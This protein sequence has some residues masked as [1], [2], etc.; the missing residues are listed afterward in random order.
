MKS[1]SGNARAESSGKSRGTPF[2]SIKSKLYISFGFLIVVFLI[3][4]AGA[5]GIQWYFDYRVTNLFN[6]QIRFS[7]LVKSSES[8]LLEIQ[9]LER[10]F[11]ATY[12]DGGTDA[13]KALLT[14]TGN[15]FE[16]IHGSLRDIQQLSV[17]QENIDMAK[18]FD[19]AVTSYEK[20]L[21]AVVAL[22]EK[23]IGPGGVESQLR[24]AGQALEDFFRDRTMNVSG[25]Q[26]MRMYEQRYL[27]GET[28]AGDILTDAIGQIKSQMDAARVAETD[29]ELLDRLCSAYAAALEAT[30][31][32]DAQ[33][34]T[35]ISQYRRNDDKIQP[36]LW[37]FYT[38]GLRDKNIA[39]ENMKRVV[40][41][42][43]AATAVCILLFLV[44]GFGR[45]VQLS[46]SITRQV[47]HI[48]NIFEKIGI[49]D[50]SARAEVT[51]NDEL[52]AMAASLNGML[53]NIFELIQT[54]EERNSMQAS[55]MKLLDDVSGIADGDLS[56]EAEVTQDFTGAIA[57]AFNFAIVQL[58]Q[59]VHNVQDST[60]RVSSSASDISSAAERLAA[61][62]E[63][64]AQRISEATSKMGEMAVAA[65]GVA[66]KAGQSAAVSDQALDAAKQGA[67][68]VLDTIGGMNRIRDKV[69]E[70]AKRIKRLGE[71]SQEIG[72]IVQMIN[73]IADRTSI[74]AMNASIQAAM[75]G[76]SGRGFAVVAEE[77]ER[78]AQ[79]S[80]KSTK[81]ITELV[82]TIQSETNE[83]VVAMEETTM[84]VVAGS[85]LAN[86]A[87]QALSQIENVSTTMAEIIS[88]IAQ[89]ARKQAQSS[90]DVAQL[91]NHIS[92]ATQ[93][94]AAGARRAALSITSLAGMAD[95]LRGSVNVFK[96]PEDEQPRELA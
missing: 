24:A 27:L 11:F 1:K 7:D 85:E 30:K 59:L 29:R 33:I 9:V 87:G 84:E 5:I 77:V 60:F 47:Q 32:S 55:L 82:K 88:T 44:I 58:R 36:L 76:E 3:V 49:G 43:I 37:Q 52:G 26:L 51:S 96:L 68:A 67:Q 80:A 6:T 28:K 53:D 35:I 22:I 90:D 89:S 46:R 45:A 25:I 64:T 63:T 10:D 23:R 92:E 72:D 81:Q 12:R 34:Q 41:V 31:Q 42:I 65:R 69:Q 62:N 20:G 54:R 15:Q 14:E 83:T 95:E 74:L 17:G 78:L 79:R 4:S 39:L 19:N 70:T 73:D 40:R 38:A 13:V 86:D 71:S 16:I 56:K 91:M 2:R 57:D 8:A 66:E 93:Q 94:A 18:E 50:Y 75:S 48:M 61:D 21:N